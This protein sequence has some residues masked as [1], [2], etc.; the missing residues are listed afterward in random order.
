MGWLAEW[1]F[2]KTAYEMH[3]NNCDLVYENVTSGEFHMSGVFP[4]VVDQ[5]LN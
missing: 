5:N 3:G 1:G 2:R 4:F